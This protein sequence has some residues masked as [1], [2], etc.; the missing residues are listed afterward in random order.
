[1][2][3]P[4]HFEVSAYLD[5]MMAPAERGQFM[6]HL[7]SCPVCQERLDALAA[8]QSQL[9]E[10]PS[11]SLGFDLA[12]RFDEQMRMAPV[13]R[14]APRTSWLSWG[15]TGVAVALSIA[16]GIWLG[17]L[18]MGGAAVAPSTA[19]ARVFDPVPPGG[20]CAAAELCRLPKGMQ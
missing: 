3:C 19:V 5:N 15:P 18:L 10:L 6:S 1:M 20:L 11:P 16:S 13:R 4:K 17:G 14:R 2:S 12:A 7:Q 9:R 8:L